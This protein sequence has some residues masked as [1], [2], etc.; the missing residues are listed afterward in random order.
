MHHEPYPAVPRPVSASGYK[1]HHRRQVK[2]LPNLEQLEHF[3]ER[4][5]VNER[6]AE[7]AG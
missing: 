3:G 2:R 6:R 4:C 7:S 1:S 5:S